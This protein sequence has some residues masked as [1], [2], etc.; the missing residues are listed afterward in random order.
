M[1]AAKTWR[2]NSPKSQP[3][4]TLGSRVRSLHTAH[5]SLLTLLFLLLIAHCSLLTD[6][7]A[8]TVV[9][10]LVASVTNGSRA[11]PDL[12]TFSDIVWQLALEPNRL[13]T[14]RPG[15]EDL[16]HALRLLESQLLILQEARRLP[17]AATEQ[18]RQDFDKGVA[19]KLTELTQAFGSR[20]K[21]EERMIRVGLTSDHLDAILRDRVTMEKYLDFRFRAFVLISPK[22]ITDRYNQEYAR[23]RNSGRIVPTLDQTRS[24]IEQELIEEKIASE[25]DAFVDSLR[26]QPGTEIVILNP[27]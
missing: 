1:Q 11:T 13:F 22:E 9:D 12:I 27:V 25:I 15:S 23:L 7:S 14:E 17:V 2:A 5:C 4:R 10:K 18:A 19:Q 8:Q 20:T 6:A 26:D 24:R 3:E 16:N 21:L